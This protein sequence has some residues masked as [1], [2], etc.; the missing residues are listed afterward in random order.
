MP[1]CL[2]RAGAVSDRARRARR[3][4]LDTA[5]GRHPTLEPRARQERSHRRCVCRSGR[6]GGRDRDIADGGAGRAGAR[7]AAA[8]RS[9]RASGPHARGAQQHLAVEPAR[10]LAGAHVARR[11]VVLEEVDDQDRPAPGTRR[12][13]H[14]CPDRTRRTASSARTHADHQGPPSRDHGAGDRA[15]CAVGGRARLRPL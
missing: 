9:P 11:C 5:D 14:A 10:P 8:G 6:V 12:A 2:R 3:S 13:D 7:S 1:A 15:R 4:R